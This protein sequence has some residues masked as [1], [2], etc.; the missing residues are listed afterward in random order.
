MPG[1]S[2]TEATAAIRA[3]PDRQRAQV[4]ILA[5]TANAFQS[6]TEQ[7]LAAGMNDCIAKPFEEAELYAKLAGLIN[8]Q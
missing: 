7:Y 3:L 6:D 4:P 2:G 8:Y 1:M 5:L